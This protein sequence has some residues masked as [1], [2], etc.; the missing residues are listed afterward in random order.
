MWLYVNVFCCFENWIIMMYFQLD[1]LSDLSWK[2]QKR[3][4]R[5]VS[6][7][8]LHKDFTV[9]SKGIPVIDSRSPDTCIR[10]TGTAQKSSQTLWAISNL[11]PCADG[12][13]YRRRKAKNCYL[14]KLW[15]HRQKNR[16]NEDATWF[17]F[18][19]TVFWSQMAN[20]WGN[21]ETCS[22]SRLWKS[23]IGQ[24][25][26][27]FPSHGSMRINIFILDEDIY[28]SVLALAKGTSKLT[29][30]LEGCKV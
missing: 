20:C 25:V 24:L 9:C 4:N 11:L 19:L 1:Q 6:Y 14:P 5:E 26:S 28:P 22:G 23:R 8:I 10:F 2:L 17:N 29:A 12:S 16:A 27:N 30:M 15:N 21:Q 3:Q 7:P 18:V 13:D